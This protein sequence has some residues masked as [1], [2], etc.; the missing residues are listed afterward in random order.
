MELS[1]IV[2]FVY[3]RPEHTRRAVE[4]LLRNNLAGKSR[5]YIFSDGAKREKDEP[6]VLAVREFI[7]SV[8]GFVKI[9][10]ILREKNLGLANSVIS[11]VNEVFQ[12]SD[13]LIVL[14]DDIVTSPSFLNFMNESLD[15]YRSNKNIFSISGFTYPINFIKKYSKDVFI[16][17]RPS[18]WGWATWSDRWNKAKW[19]KNAFSLFLKDKSLQE[20]FNRA[21][22]DLTPMLFNQIKGR[23]D[24]WAIRWAY[25]HF[26][27]NAYCL[28]P[29]VSLCRNIGMDS[30]GT[31]SSTS[32]KYDV[33]LDE[34]DRQFVL[35]S[36]L[37]I[38][39]EIFREIKDLFKLSLL[40]RIINYFKMK[41]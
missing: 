27:N 40:R 34:S 41:F 9:E 8:N 3:N 38:E 19:D 2:L 33:I 10:I 17:Y 1:P 6:K 7:K 36:D 21:G 35:N 11:G 15:F 14:E 12:F 32:N 25:A 16:S 29:K 24:S 4:S 30:S 22:D 5:L 13:R 31:H 20:K 23:I 26:E 37:A 39:D 18:S 28:F